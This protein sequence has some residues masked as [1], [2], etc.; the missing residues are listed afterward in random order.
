LPKKFC[1]FPVPTQRHSEPIVVGKNT[2]KYI[3]LNDVVYV[4]KTQ[5]LLKFLKQKFIIKFVQYEARIH[6]TYPLTT[7]CIPNFD[8]VKPG[9]NE[10][11]YNEHIFNSQLIMLLHKSRNY[12]KP[13]F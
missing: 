4:N 5:K 3:G 6:D 11:G 7:Y 13:R 10:L 12:N 2:F 8:T 9:F 1:G